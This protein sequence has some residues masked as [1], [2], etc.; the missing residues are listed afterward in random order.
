MSGVV[1]ALLTAGC[2]SSLPPLPTVPS[3]EHGF[4]QAP[5]P[6]LTGLDED[7]PQALTLMPGD[8]VNL[9][10]ISGTDSAVLGLTVDERGVL[11]VPLAGDVDVAG[12]SLTE[13]EARIEA[14]LRPFDQ[15]VR[16]TIIVAQPNGQRATVIGAVASP[17]RVTV[18][19]GMRLADLL[20]SA[21]GSAHGEEANMTVP[22]ADLH[23]ARLVRQGQVV[24][25][26]LVLAVM[27]DPRHN[28]RVRPGDH[29]YVPP[30]LEGLVSVLG[31]VH[32]ARTMPYRAGLRLTLALAFAGGPTRDADHAEIIV[33]RGD[34]AA[35]EVYV[36]RLDQ[37]LDGEGADPILAP[38]DVVYV[39]ATGLS[40]LRDVMAAI[41]PV[42]SVAA[43]TGLGAAVVSTSR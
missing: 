25:V 32:A 9:Q 7:P 30:Q 35:P 38:G 41:A 12:L 4:V 23:G 24:P 18:V 14:A 27:G 3:A 31:E 2:G 16:V 15:T 39:G 34:H 40:K 5:A 43:T 37:L 1:L 13:G 20:A 28:V 17:G 36:A 10:M 19:P 22:L 42:V 21:G 29:L 6:E 8:V 33:V 26:S 11:H